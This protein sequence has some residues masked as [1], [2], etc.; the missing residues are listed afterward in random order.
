MDSHETNDRVFCSLCGDD[1]GIEQVEAGE[2]IDHDRCRE[3]ESEERER[4]I[5]HAEYDGRGYR[6][7]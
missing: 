6:I 1:I 3:N 4:R 2:E 5:V 7:R